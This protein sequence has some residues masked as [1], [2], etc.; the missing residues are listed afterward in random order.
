MHLHSVHTCQSQLTH[1]LCISF[2]IMWKFVSLSS[3]AV[4]FEG[5][6]LHNYWTLPLVLCEDAFRT[7]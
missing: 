4:T 2:S 5:F 6:S 7:P 1:N 3:R